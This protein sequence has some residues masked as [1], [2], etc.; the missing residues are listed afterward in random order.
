MKE[1][2]NR[3]RPR[4]GREIFIVICIKLILLWCLWHYCFSHPVEKPLRKTLIE[5]T[6]FFNK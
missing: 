3:Q 5:K 6:L 1:F 2:N 4:L